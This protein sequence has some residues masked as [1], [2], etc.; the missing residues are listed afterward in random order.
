MQKKSIGEDPWDFV[1]P[2]HVKMFGSEL[3]SPDKKAIWCKA[4]FC[5]GSTLHLWNKAVELKLTL[6]SACALKG[7][8]RVVLI[9]KY[10]AESGLVQA[11]RSL[12]SQKDLLV[13]EEIAPQALAAFPQIHPATGK[14]L[15]WNFNYFDSLPDESLDRVILFGATSHIGN[16]EECVRH[17]YRILRDRGRVII[18]DAPWGGEDLV[19]AAHM[20]AHLEGFVTRILAGMKLKEEELP[21]IGPED[22]TTLFKS[23][24][25]WSRAISWQGLYLFYGQK[26]GSEGNAS[27]DFPLPTEAVQI[28]LTEK[29]SMN[30]WHFLTASEIAT[31]GSEVAESKLQKN[32]GRAIFFASCLAWCWANSKTI[33]HLMYSNLRVKPGNR[34]K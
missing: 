17:I 2:V 3:L 29:A 7:G 22:L 12:L 14:R 27:W 9:G 23:V 26:G 31:L 15:Q 32:W 8:Q 21:H 5:G 20:D 6:L 34:V 18:A 13:V 24:L 1:L 19:T 28:F 11:L 33:K 25:R 4:F 10:C 16:L 30:P